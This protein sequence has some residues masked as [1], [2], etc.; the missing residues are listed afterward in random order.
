MLLSDIKILF[1]NDAHQDLEMVDRLVAL[2]LL[3]EAVENRML[4]SD[5]VLVLK[6]QRRKAT[7]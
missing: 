7:H 3:I 2:N 1:T 5:Q 4:V 6:H